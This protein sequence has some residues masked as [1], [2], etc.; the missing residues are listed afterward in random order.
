MNVTIIPEDNLVKVD[1][2]ALRLDL[3]SIAINMSNW[4]AV[5][6][7]NGQGAVEHRDGTIASTFTDLSFIQPFIDLHT[8][9]LAE[10]NAPPSIDELRA[11]AIAT[12]EAQAQAFIV[13]GFESAALGT[14][15]T[16]GGKQT[17]Q[18]NL[19]GAAGSGM[20]MTYP[21][22]DSDGVWLRR[23]HTHE[24][25]KIVLVDGSTHKQIILSTLDDRRAAVMAAADENELNTI[26]AAGLI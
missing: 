5:Q 25:L 4:H 8:A 13:Q 15:H 11:D 24:Q 23:L 21:C 19:I 3:S 10:L 20:D 6:Y 22:G 14:L 7:A 26:L 18:L 16:Y 9:R 17:D 2:I 1:G 12:L